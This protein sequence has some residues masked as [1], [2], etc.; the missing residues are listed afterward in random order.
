MNKDGSYLKEEWYLDGE[1]S[2]CVASSDI[3]EVQIGH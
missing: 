3:T 2:L 1:K